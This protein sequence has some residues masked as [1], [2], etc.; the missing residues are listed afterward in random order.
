MPAR[1]HEPTDE[2]RTQVRSL[3]GLGIPHRDIAPFV[4][5]SPPTLRKHYEHELQQGKTEANAKVA[6]SLFRK[7]VGDGPG[8]VTAAI[9][10]LK[11]QA[12]WK[13]VHTVEVQGGDGAPALVIN[14]TEGSPPEDWE[15]G[16]PYTIDGSAS[17]V[18]SSPGRIAGPSDPD[19]DH[20]L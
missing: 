7:A 14:V 20:D 4:G 6:Q 2:K 18:D 19:Q 13:D 11:A 17:A 5:I 3:A 1:Q 9:F 8:S 10:W 16:G 15:R 12:G